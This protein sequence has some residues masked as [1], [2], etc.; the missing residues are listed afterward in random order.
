MPSGSPSFGLRLDDNQFWGDNYL[1]GGE[2]NGCGQGDS[3][4]TFLESVRF[5]G[6]RFRM[7]LLVAAL[8]AVGCGPIS[9]RTHIDSVDVI[10]YGGLDYMNR[11]CSGPA[12][13]D[14]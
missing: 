11:W 6:M 3:L 1:G 12:L 8:L 2:S 9:G 10:R 13:D 7:G 14:A 5:I 4:R